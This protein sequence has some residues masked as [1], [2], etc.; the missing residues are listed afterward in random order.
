MRAYWLVCIA[1]FGIGCSGGCGSSA[2]TP[3]QG[4][5][6]STTSGT[7]E[8]E[9]EPTGPGTTTNANG[10]GEAIPARLHGEVERFAAVPLFENHG[11]ATMRLAKT[12]E[13]ERKNGETF[14]RLEGV[15]ELLLRESCGHAPP[16][17]IELAPGA[18]LAPP[19]WNGQLGDTAQCACPGC[20]YAESGTY[21]FVARTC[22][23]ARI[24]GEPFDWAP[25]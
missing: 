4:G 10:R 6:G 22:D 20:T 23:G 11:R 16:D 9:G 14:T 3:P 7:G 19:G 18:M 8:A 13:V 2:V 12:L 15:G 17:C 5:S 1:A 21:R 24:E 25:P